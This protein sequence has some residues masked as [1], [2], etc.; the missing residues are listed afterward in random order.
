LTNQANRRRVGLHIGNEARHV[1][2]SIWNEVFI[3]NVSVKD[4]AILFS[5]LLQKIVPPMQTYLRDIPNS[6]NITKITE[7]LT[8][9]LPCL[10][11]KYYPFVV[12]VA[13][14]SCQTICCS[15]HIL[16]LW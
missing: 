7:P 9:P 5:T 3:G 2:K 6:K 16:L 15:I 4:G 12:C 8:Y 1:W 14:Y 10:G 11:T 13:I